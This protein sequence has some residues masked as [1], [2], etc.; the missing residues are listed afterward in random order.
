M[1]TLDGSLIRRAAVAASLVLCVMVTRPAAAQQ[2]EPVAAPAEASFFA[3]YNFHMSAAALAIDDPRFSWDT[4]FGGELDVVD[5]VVGRTSVLVDFESVLGDEYRAFDP[6]QGNYTLEVSS[7]ARV[8]ETEIAA[9][10]HHVS[11]HLSDRPKTFAI[12]WN[13][14]GAR[15]LRHEELG[16]TTV[17]VDVDAG[18]IVQ[19][20]YADYRWVGDANLRVGRPLSSRVGV[21]ARGAGHVFGVDSAVRGT[22]VGGSVEGGVRIGGKDGVLELFAGVERRVD[23]DPIDF[24][25]QHWVQA[26]FRLLRR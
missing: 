17:D 25:A 19:H 6:N 10:F 4:H 7:S 23:A 9:M 8:G 3:R 21:F 26:G 1:S 2:Q 11:R 13:V 20:S 16:A 22:Q 18:A 12:A 5:Y 24:T 14:L 15:V